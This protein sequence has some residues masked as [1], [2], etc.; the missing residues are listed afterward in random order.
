MFYSHTRSCK[1]MKLSEMC[2]VQT[3]YLRKLFAKKY[4]YTVISEFWDY[5]DI[6]LSFF[7]CMTIKIC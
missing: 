2:L 7:Y 3:I 1:H 4:C 6:F 5:Q